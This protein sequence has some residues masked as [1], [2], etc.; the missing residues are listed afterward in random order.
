MTTNGVKFEE[1]GEKLAAAG[2]DGVN[3]SLDCL[4][5]VTFYAIT[6]VDAF[7]D[8]IKGIELSLKLK[9]RTR[10]NCVPIGELN[11]DCVNT[12]AS[13]AQ[14]YPLDMRFIELMPIGLGKNY[15]PVKGEIILQ[16]LAGE[17][18]E[19]VPS[20]ATHGNG[21]A[22]YYDF[23]GFKG[24][25][26]FISP[27]SSVF[28]GS[29]NRVRLTAEGALKPCLCCKEALDLKPLLRNGAT[30]SQLAQAMQKAI[31]YKPL[32]H[33]LDD[34]SDKTAETKNMVQIGG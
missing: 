25:I 8:V 14:R 5:K 30:E 17:Y 16:K 9:L 13:L 31:F 7:S 29:C 10:V 22:A 4:D 1:M 20:L 32:R 19:P 12:M 3:F 33:N 21:P 15:T 23:P 11:S 26:G 34:A 18:G 28:C 24:S 2:L 6:R 27:I